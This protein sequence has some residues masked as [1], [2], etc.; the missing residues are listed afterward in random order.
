V[1]ERFLHRLRK[2]HPDAIILTGDGRGV[3][4]QV[5]CD[6][7]GLGCE[8][9]QP[10]LHPEW[11]GRQAL[12]CQI[13]DIVNGCDVL[14]IVGARTA[15]RARLA[16]DIFNRMEMMQRNIRGGLALDKR[17]R[18]ISR[19]EPEHQRKLVYIS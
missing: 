15:S 5:V 1:L 10:A 12:A 14:V 16:V 4:A 3:E 6:A 18:P 9:E 2:H 8:V 11:F 13:N 17:G 7:T 19:R